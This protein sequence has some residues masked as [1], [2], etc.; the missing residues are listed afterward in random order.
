MPQNPTL[1]QKWPRSGVTFHLVTDE[2]M[3]LCLYL[4]PRVKLKAIARSTETLFVGKNR[5]T[6]WIFFLPF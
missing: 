3:G 2:N 6:C 4:F 5:K 1:P